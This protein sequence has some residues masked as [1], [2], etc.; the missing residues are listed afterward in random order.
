MVREIVD[1]TGGDLVVV[2]GVLVPMAAWNLIL[3]QDRI[4]CAF[5]LLCLSQI[6]S[7]GA[8]AVGERVLRSF[9]ER[10]VELRDVRSVLRVVCVLV[11]MRKAQ[12]GMGG[13]S[14]EYANPF[15]IFTLMKSSLLYSF[16][17][18]ACSKLPSLL[19]AVCEYVRSSGSV[20]N[21]LCAQAVSNADAAAVGGLVDAYSSTESEIPV[22][23]DLEKAVEDSAKARSVAIVAYTVPD[24][25]VHLRVA[26]G[27]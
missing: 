1:R 11:G 5:L 14:Q 24:S 13:D 23:F 7:S 2:S 22:D 15:H 26:L 19:P 20:I 18:L 16:V 6:N 9:L 27:L 17:E 21:A 10:C 25:L 3:P 8:D 12:S 4:C